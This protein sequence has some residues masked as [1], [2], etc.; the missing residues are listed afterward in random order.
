MRLGEDVLTLMRTLTDFEAS[1]IIQRLSNGR[2]T[3]TREY[4]LILQYQKYTQL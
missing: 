2:Y 3:P 4:H 1:G